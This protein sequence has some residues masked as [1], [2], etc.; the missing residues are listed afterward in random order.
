MDLSNSSYSTI[1]D[2]LASVYSAK[3]FNE[4]LARLPTEG[5]L[6]I[7]HE[8]IES[9]K[10]LLRHAGV[11]IGDVTQTI[12][13]GGHFTFSLE[14]GMGNA[15]RVLQ[16]TDNFFLQL[17]LAGHNKGTEFPELKPLLPEPDAWIEHLL[18]VG[19]L[20]QLLLMS[21]GPDAEQRAVRFMQP[22]TPFLVELFT[23]CKE[24]R[25]NSLRR[26]ASMMKQQVQRHEERLKVPRQ[27]QTIAL[28][29]AFETV[30]FG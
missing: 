2:T 13:T 11:G 20:G 27:A 1:G 26:L 7:L 8:Q 19:E 23:V 15:P 14:T 28:K 25:I 21:I 16:L 12:C 18:F 4:R 9:C 17:M 29:L 5:F 24:C 6:K 3:P 10:P 30:L 22:S